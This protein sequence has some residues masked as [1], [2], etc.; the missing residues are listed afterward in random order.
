[1]QFDTF[2]DTIRLLRDPYNPLVLDVVQNGTNLTPQLPMSAVQEIK[3]TALG[4]SDNLIVDGSNGMIQVDQFI[5]TGGDEGTQLEIDGNP[6]D[7][8]TQA[9][10]NSDTGYVFV[11]GKDMGD[12][13]ERIFYSHV[14]VVDSTLPNSLGS[15]QTVLDTM[16]NGLQTLFGWS[17]QLA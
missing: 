10:I 16:R 9:S 6:G 14:P 4:G 15:P 1:I 5:Y 11:Q 3:A 8:F 2:F 12:I 13:G 7:V 17:A